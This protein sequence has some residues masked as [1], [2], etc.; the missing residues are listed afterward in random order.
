MIPQRAIPNPNAIRKR[1]TQMIRDLYR[2]ALDE[3][4]SRNILWLHGPAGAGKSA[5]MQTL[6]GQLRDAGKLGGSF[7]FK[8]SHA[9]RGNARTLFATIAYQLALSIP[10]MRTWISEAVQNDPSVVFRSIAT[11]FEILIS[12]ACRTH[13][14]RGCIPILIDGLDEC[15]GQSDQVEVLRTIGNLPFSDPIPLRFIIASRPEP[16]IQEVFDSSFHPGQYRS[17]NVEQSFHDVHKYLWD[18]FSRIHREHRTMADIPS[19]WPSTDVLWELV[20]KSSGH[21]IYA[22]TIIKFINDKNY[23][24][25]QRLAM[26]LGNSSQGLPFGALDQLYMDILSSAPRQSELVP[27][28]CAIANFQ[29]TISEMDQ[30][31]EFTEGE[32]RLLLLWTIGWIWH[33]LS[34]E[35]VQ[36]EIIHG[37]GSV[38]LGHGAP[39]NT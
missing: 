26:V 15:D 8:R 29:L 28:L 16:H 4:A 37:I 21:F 22:A 17:F 14:D 12:A 38:I 1:G 31:F 11:Q 39:G 13:T 33:G 7:F 27:I 25:T 5:I 32:T 24:P 6:A 30:L 2:W 18:E 34:F 19:P 23:R 35:F 36:I 10:G 3:G 9:T 20:W